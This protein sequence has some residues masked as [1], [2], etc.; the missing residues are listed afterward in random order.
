MV[1]PDA[2]DWDAVY[3]TRVLPNLGV[4][5]GTSAPLRWTFV[6]G[7][8]GSGKS[9][10]IRQLADD[11]GPDTTQVISGDALCALVPELFADPD[12]PALAEAHRHY[13]RHVQPAQIDALIERAATLRAHVLWECHVPADILALAS[14]ARQLGYHVAC[15]VLAVPPV[16]SWLAT[17]RRD[18][19]PQ[20][21]FAKAV[22]W[23]T[24]L[25]SYHLWPAFL[26]RAEQDVAFDTLR[27]VAR[28][29]SAYVEN[30]AVQTAP[31]RWSGPAFACESLL[32]ERLQPRSRAE[33]QAALAEW[34]HL[35]AAPALCFRNTPDWPYGSLMALDAALH[36]RCDDPAYGFDLNTPADPETAA[37]WIS[38]LRDDLSAACDAAAPADLPLLRSRGDRLLD[39]VAALTVAP[40]AHPTR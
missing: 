6:C 24:H 18:L 29:G 10:R 14:V 16:E 1:S 21:A 2:L 39:L 15:E 9:T 28:D 26:A 17:L 36:A 34:R 19:A 7:Q 12:D 30:T 35:R 11:L 13:A 32:V 23:A 8:P 5:S 3:Q 38:R 22:S 33:R 20:T 31:P 37:R 27:I 40:G 25:R 4:R